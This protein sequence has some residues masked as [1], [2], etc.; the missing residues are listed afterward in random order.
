LSSARIGDGHPVRGDIRRLGDGATGVADQE[1][2]LLLYTDGVT[3][4]RSPHGVFY[5]LAERAATFPPAG[6][7]ELL[8]HLLR[9][10]TAHTGGRLSD[11]V[12][13]LAIGRIPVRARGSAASRRS[14]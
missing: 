6:P 10:V 12:A 5:P 8:R 13:V 4:A 7:E 2:G 14:P 3:G 1:R 9:D 11:G